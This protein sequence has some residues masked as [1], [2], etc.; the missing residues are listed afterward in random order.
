MR[1]NWY[2]EALEVLSPLRYHGWQLVQ[3][4]HK[5]PDTD[6]S[7]LVSK[8]KINELETALQKVEKFFLT[9]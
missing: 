8:E 7:V 9:K 3:H 4:Q 1:D 6:K 2:S 5:L